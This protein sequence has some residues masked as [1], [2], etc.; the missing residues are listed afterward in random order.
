M[1]IKS[2]IFQHPVDI[3]IWNCTK[4]EICRNSCSLFVHYC[5]KNL[6][7]DTRRDSSETSEFSSFREFRRTSKKRWGTFNSRTGHI[8]RKLQNSANTL[9][10]S[11]SFFV[12]KSK[13]SY[14]PLIAKNDFERTFWSL[15]TEL[16]SVGDLDTDK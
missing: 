5:H 10:W 2:S 16:N 15:I 1:Q 8:N 9:F 13:T 14:L 4:E 3:E 7:K 12:I 11:F 6:V